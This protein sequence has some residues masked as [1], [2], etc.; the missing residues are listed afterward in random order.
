[1]TVVNEDQLLQ[2]TNPGVDD[3]DVALQFAAAEVVVGD[4]QLRADAPQR[5]GAGVPQTVGRDLV[6][7]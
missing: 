3:G 1:M 7:L 2:F 4:A 5:P 6:V